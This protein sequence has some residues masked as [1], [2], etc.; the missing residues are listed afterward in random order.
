MKKISDDQIVKLLAS[1]DGQQNNEALRYLYHSHYEI[2]AKMV[3]K[4]SGSEEEAKDIFQDGLIVLYNQTKKPNFKLSSALQ[5][6][7]FAICRNLWL[8][9]LRRKKREVKLDD[10]F[11]FLP[12]IGDSQLEVLIGNER[13]EL[14]VQ[15]LDQL[16]DA[17]KQVLHYFYFERLKMKEIMKLMNLSSEQVTKNKKANCLKKLRKFVLESPTYQQNLKSTD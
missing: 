16:G 11:N 9:K 1:P 4:N 13:Q 5:T 2:V 15:L 14:V 17:C 3:Y 8:M 12:E 6:F 7:L 10:S